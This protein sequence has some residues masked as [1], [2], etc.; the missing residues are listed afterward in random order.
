MGNLSRQNKLNG[1]S[2]VCLLLSW[3]VL[4]YGSP[5][6]TVANTSDSSGFVDVGVDDL[7]AQLDQLIGPESTDD[8]LG[9]RDASSWDEQTSPIVSQTGGFAAQEEVQSQSRSSAHP[10]A[11][12]SPPV[13][14]RPRKQGVVN[15]VW[16]KR[17]K[18][19]AKKFERGGRAPPNLSDNLAPER[20][21]EPKWDDVLFFQSQESTV[22]KN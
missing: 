18:L 8:H 3:G 16:N 20:D 10:P 1:E 4:V 22:T 5:N 11:P 12:S 2:A 7:L 21:D 6:I 17:K 19:F 13:A 9:V 15:K 14:P